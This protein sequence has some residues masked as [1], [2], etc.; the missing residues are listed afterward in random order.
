MNSVTSH[1]NLEW[2]TIITYALERENPDDTIQ[3]LLEYLGKYYLASRSYVFEFH[4]TPTFS[5]TYEWCSENMPSQIEVLQNESLFH[6][7]Y[8]VDSFKDRKP[9]II[10]D[11][12]EI[13]FTQPATYALLKTQLVKSVV[14]VPCFLE[15]KLIG[16]IGADN[17]DKEHMLALVADL[18]YVGSIISQQIKTRNLLE[19]A[20]FYQ[21]HDPVTQFYNKNALHRD[22]EK[23]KEL[24][25]FGVISCIVSRFPNAMDIH[26][27]DLKEE[28]TYFEWYSVLKHV[29]HNFAIYQLSPDNVVILCENISESVFLDKISILR[30]F[31]SRNSFHLLLGHFWSDK[32]PLSRKQVLENAKNAM[33][34][35]NPLL[36][37]TLA[38]SKNIPIQTSS[39]PSCPVQSVQTSSL[40]NFIANNYF[41]LNSFFQSMSIG[42]LYPY[43][44]DLSSDLW[45]ISDSMKELLGFSSNIV[46]SLL[47]RWEDFIPY[48]EDLE[49]Y[50]NDVA[51]IMSFKKIFM[52]LF[53][54]SWTA[55][56]MSF[57]FVVSVLSHGTATVRHRFLFAEMFS[58]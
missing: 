48:K 43:F 47:K 8:W 11:V 36:S 21:F 1:L 39:N 18:E 52:T 38:L 12:E 54:V 23:T 34:L 50:R 58:V 20:I 14:I 30:D 56:E 25:S 9:I 53:I 15:D 41:D 27:A 28:Y 33:P 22:L 5:N 44:G 10:E 19:K 46:V 57:G 7:A 37:S 29:F 35:S 16:F 13:R 6:I 17:P 4:E 40:N 49:L 51:N 3:I 32:Q 42:G 2:K 26:S 24:S 55:T 45:Y 31:T